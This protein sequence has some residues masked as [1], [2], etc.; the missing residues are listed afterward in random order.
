MSWQQPFSIARRAEVSRRVVWFFLG[1]LAIAFFRVQVIGSSRYRLQ[2][3]ENRLRPIPI[4]AA[5]GLV[6]DRNG[7]V[8]AEN[9][10]GYTVG[11]IASSVDSLRAMLRRIAPVVHLDSAAF[12]LLVRRFRRHPY[13]PVVITR[14]APFGLVSSLEERR[15]LIPGL[16]IQA[17]PKRRY[18]LGSV[19]A[20]V[21]GY[22]NEITERELSSTKFAN[23]RA[24]ALVGRDGLERQYDDALR[25]EDGVRYVEVDALGH[26][27]PAAGVGSQLDP[28]Q[29]TTLRTTLDAPLQEFVASV[30]P[31]NTRGAVMVMDP[32]TGEL[33][34]IYS[35]P[36][37]DPNLFI[38][39]GDPKVLGELLKSDAHPLL[40][41]AIQARYPPASPWKLVMAS[42]AL[43]R[44]VIS[45]DSRMPQ[46]C[47]GGFQYYNRYFHCWKAEG[48]GDV[49]LAEAIQ[50]SC[51][52]YFYQLGLKLGLSEVLQDGVDLGFRDRSGIDLPNEV[53]PTF[54]S[55]TDYYDRLYGRRGWTPG[56]VL[57][58]AIGQGENAQTLANMMR[59]YTM[60]ANP[61][62]EAPTPSLVSASTAGMRALGLS[63]RSLNGLRLALLNVVEHGTAAASR[64]EG[65]KIAG[66]TGTAQNPHGPNHGWFIAFAPVDSPKVVVGGILEFAGHGTVVAPIVNRIIAHHLLGE[67]AG[68][69]T[70]YQLLLPDDSAPAPQLILPDTSVNRVTAN[71]GPAAR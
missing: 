33:L 50:G 47:R 18:P 67:G 26:T 10:P 4:P 58:L 1:L 22:V 17:E 46:P 25:G 66:K 19:T 5:R 21:V 14:D 64:I 24:G 60:L 15:M 48:H 52:V 55:S 70:D 56:V 61:S 43:K 38:G 16:V 69:A 8:L 28:R 40:D 44:G 63:D 59:F 54:P 6:T 71:A 11:L 30:I 36:S 13:E 51:D 23:V 27:V 68:P 32:A 49:T 42:I 39:G 29:G 41:R 45:L 37:Y 7:V 31:P 53:S 2:S 20:H 9:V 12:D 35:S 3:E 34:A 57:N 62:G 65:L